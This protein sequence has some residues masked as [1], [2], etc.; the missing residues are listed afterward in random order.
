[1]DQPHT[2]DIYAAPHYIIRMG[3]KSFEKT[4]MFLP[5]ATHTKE[6]GR[7]TNYF[8]L[9]AG[10]ASMQIAIIYRIYIRDIPLPGTCIN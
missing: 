10:K 5:L 3:T 7:R 6:R 4:L 8:I 9:L 2:P 1:M